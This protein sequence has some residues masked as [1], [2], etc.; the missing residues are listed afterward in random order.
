[1]LQRKV[2]GDK[3]YVDDVNDL[4]AANERTERIGGAATNAAGISIPRGNKSAQF[5]EPATLAQAVNSTS[6]VLPRYAVCAIS[7]QFF[8]GTLMQS[9]RY[10]TLSTPASSD[11]GWFA[12][13]AEPIAPNQ[14]GRVYVAGICVALLQNPD[15]HELA[16]ITPSQNY[17]TGSS[18]GSAQILWED[19]F[20]GS[21]T[22]LALV[23]FP[24]GSGSGI[25]QFQISSVGND[26]I[27]AY[28]YDNITGAGSTAVYI[29]K[30]WLLRRTPF[31]GHSRNGISYSY[32]ID[33][34]SR[35]ASRSGI[36]ETE[37]ITPSYQVGDL[38][39]AAQNP[40][41][42]PLVISG[43]PPITITWIDLNADGRSWCK[44]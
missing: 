27:S 41:G 30:P 20:T 17:L 16:E 28:P 5:C 26:Y 15:H 43:S 2:S 19:S 37:S 21:A 23:R 11:S 40:T 35:T 22:H 4:I 25:G 1:M 44:Q 36:S 42:F 13:T 24:L 18:S 34:L 7:G 8:T 31:D 39:Y 12:I 10:L 6:A 14:T 32:S 9:Q 33:G 3:I 29:A 38:I